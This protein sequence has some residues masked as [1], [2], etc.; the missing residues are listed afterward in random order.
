MALAPELDFA[1]AC[2]ASDTV[3]K[4]LVAAV[5]SRGV[6]CRYL[7]VNGALPSFVLPTDAQLS[8]VGLKLTGEEWLTPA[9]T[10]RLRQ[11]FQL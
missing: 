10:E 11:F 2:E 3:S 5:K 8:T 9:L 4:Q 6:N 1:G 7:R